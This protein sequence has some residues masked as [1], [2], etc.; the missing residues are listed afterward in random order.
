MKRLHIAGGALVFAAVFLA[1]ALWPRSTG[2]GPEPVRW[3]R[4]A[5]AH[6]RM[7]LSRPGFA[8]ELRDRD[9]RL[10]RYDDLGC[11]FTALARVHTQTPEGWV[12][13][14]A[15]HGWVPLLGATFVRGAGSST[16]MGSGLL[17][18]QGADEA[19]AFGRAHAATV[20][21]F[22]DLLRSGGQEAAEGHAENEVRKG[23]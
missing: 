10:T 14:H 8:G 1:V 4:D 15:G 12:E 6:C 22:E 11:L 3:G 19:S 7:I 16:P 2:D 5:C 18:F 20:V 13:D 21:P 17:A 9:G 23:P